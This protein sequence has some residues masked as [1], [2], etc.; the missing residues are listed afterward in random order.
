LN[1]K[2]RVNELN[3]ELGK[4]MKKDL[5][6]YQYELDRFSHNVQRI[7]QQLE[8]I[9]NI[10][11]SFESNV[12][13]NKAFYNYYLVNMLLILSYYRNEILIEVFEKYFYDENSLTTLENQF[14]SK[15]DDLNQIDD[16][17]NIF[18]NAKFQ[19]TGMK[20]PPANCPQCKLVDLARRIWKFPAKV[21]VRT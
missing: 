15:I 10:S 17:A 4:S 7:Y 9:D 1:T 2:P 18:T 13:R 21:L 12:A 11:K 20:S 5:P 14:L 3:D 6:V 19:L 16:F 8:E